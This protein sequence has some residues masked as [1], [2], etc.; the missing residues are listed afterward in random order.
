MSKNIAGLVAVLA[1]VTSAC[2]TA[3]PATRVAYTPAGQAAQPG[4]WGGASTQQAASTHGVPAG[5]AAQPGS[6]VGQE[7]PRDHV[8]YVTG[9]PAG[10]A[11]QPYG[12]S[13]S[14]L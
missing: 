1:L 5:Q 9:Q 8:V 3:A 10:R 4:S 6:W 14:S 2:A 12:W 11:S 7:Q 13:K